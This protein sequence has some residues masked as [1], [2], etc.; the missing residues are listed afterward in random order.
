MN[1]GNM[2]RGKYV[3][4]QITDLGGHAAFVQATSIYAIKSDDVKLDPCNQPFCFG[5]TSPG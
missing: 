4:P 2:G 1:Q 5:S 3:A